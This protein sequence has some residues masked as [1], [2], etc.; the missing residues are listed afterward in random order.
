M[1]SSEKE[2]MEKLKQKELLFSLPD[3]ILEQIYNE[4]RMVLY[5]GRKRNMDEK[6]LKIINQ[7]AS[8]LD[9]EKLREVLEENDTAEN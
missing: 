5:K 9:S 7:Y 2:I 1:S 3:G 4:E 8:T 6:I